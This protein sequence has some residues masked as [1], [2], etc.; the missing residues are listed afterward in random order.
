MIAKM[1]AADLDGWFGQAHVYE[2]DPPMQ[3]GDSDQNAFTFYVIVSAVVAP[4]TGPETYIFPAEKHGDVFKTIN[5]RELEGSFRGALDH[6][7]ALNN[8]GY[9][10]TR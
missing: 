3:Y 6:E 5:Y 9:E 1:I 2:M 4:Y 8:A 7:A 10:V